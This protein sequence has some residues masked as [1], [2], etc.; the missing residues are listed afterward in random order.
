MVSNYDCSLDNIFTQTHRPLRSP[1]KIV[2][3]AYNQLERYNMKFQRPEASGK[4][5]KRLYPTW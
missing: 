3:M 1:F 4:E 2:K 5:M